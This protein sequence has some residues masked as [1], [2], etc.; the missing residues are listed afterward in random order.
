MKRTWFAATVVA[1]L[2]SPAMNAVA[3]DLAYTK[4]PVVAVYNWTGL[5]VGGTVGGGWQRSRT[6]YGSD[7]SYPLG[8][9]IFIP[10]QDFGVLARSSSQNGAG[11][12]GGVTLGYNWQRSAVV[13]GVEGDWSWTGLKATSVVAPVPCCFFPTLTTTTETRT[14]WLATLRGRIGVL[15]APQT[16]LFVTGGLA[17]GEIKT[18]TT[19]VPSSATSSCA[20][21]SLCAAGVASA[22]RAGWTVGAGL[23]QGFAGNWTVKVEY[24]HYDLG[25]VSHI[26]TEASPGFP[27]FLGQ[28]VLN[29]NTKV[30]GEIGRVGV[31]YR[32]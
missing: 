22:T 21:N 27:V 17:L 10:A 28:P 8:P 31:N 14:D 2:A 12:L 20:N 1:A 6:D 15:A 30:S 32:F 16:L 29:V 23:E 3:A 7:P 9:I 11:V 25:S 4:A 18:S 13:L 26:A 5:Y 19:V 24:L